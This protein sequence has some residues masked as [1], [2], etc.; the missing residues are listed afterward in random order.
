M[1]SG[2]FLID[3]ESRMKLAAA[4]LFGNVV[5]DPV[6]GMNLDEGKAKT[7]GLKSEH[8]GKSYYFC[9]DRCKRQFDTD[10]TRYLAESTPDQGS[11]DHTSPGSD[12]KVKA[13]IVKD[14]VCGAQVDEVKAKEAGRT[15]EYQ[16]KLYYFC[17]DNCKQRFAKAPKVFCGESPGD[18]GQGGAATAPVLPAVS[19]DPVCGLDV[20]EQL[21]SAGLPTTEYKG[22]I[23]YFCSEHCKEAFN[24]EPERY[25]SQSSGIQVPAI[26]PEGGPASA[27][28]TAPQPSASIKATEPGLIPPSPPA[29]LQGVQPRDLSKKG[30]LVPGVPKGPG[31]D[32][33]GR[34]IPGARKAPSDPK[35]AVPGQAGEAGQGPPVSHQKDLKPIESDE[36]KKMTTPFVKAE[37][38]P[39]HLLMPPKD[40][41]AKDPVCGIKL[42]EAQAK[43]MPWK[44]D[45]Q[46][47][48]Y[49][50]CSEKCKS[51]FDK[52]PP[53][54]IPQAQSAGPAPEAQRPA[55]P[56]ARA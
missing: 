17:S 20:R 48:T 29:G 16:G 34:R 7:A 49:F 27:E 18:Q 11:C 9:S 52:N 24:K 28:K 40:P 6:C 13:E 22:K 50:F 5:K 51:Q 42:D 35:V 37:D 47:K 3:S 8:Q 46:G 21:S 41:G 44:S 26:I 10:P 25:L 4:G 12:I 56:A 31:Y 45:Y 2:N 36:F 1:V 55:Q 53:Q 43:S 32:I 15:G 14:P 33:R 39:I 23:Y 19:I 54:F 30:G 38:I